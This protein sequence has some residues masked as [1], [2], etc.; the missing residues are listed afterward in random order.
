MDFFFTI[1]GKLFD[2]SR[3]TVKWL[4]HYITKQCEIERICRSTGYRSRI[5]QSLAL[6]SSIK[7]SKQLK[8]IGSIIF[9]P[10]PFT[11][12]RVL[13]LIVTVKKINE[14]DNTVLKV[15]SCL[16]DIRVVNM[17]YDKLESLKKLKYNEQTKEMVH[18]Q[19]DELWSRLKPD[20]MRRR[21]SSGS[22]LSDDWSDIGFQGKDPTTDFRGMGLL[23]LYQLLHFSRTRPEIAQKLLLECDHPRRY[24]PFA[25]TG[26]NLS[27]FTMELIS[28]SR[29]YKYI[30][31]N[32]PAIQHCDE[33]NTTS[34]TETD[35]VRAGVDT[36]HN[37]YCEVFEAFM[38][39]WVARDP[40]DIMSFQG[41][42]KEFKLSIR[43]KYSEL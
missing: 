31:H 2:V 29:L 34:S 40:Q 32:V 23:G 33:F 41:I 12:P 21:D 17:I 25:A 43:R 6:G 5:E 36:V 18:S 19:L 14:Q 1:V 28:E 42:F 11:I 38:K 15:T 8:S 20:I 26:I 3:Q 37:L 9:Y 16:N 4:L 27:L 7:R 35:A 39:L 10:K 22:L 24:I 30:L 13:P